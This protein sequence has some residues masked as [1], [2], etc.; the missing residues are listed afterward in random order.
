[1]YVHQNNCKNWCKINKTHHTMY[2]CTRFSAL[3]YNPSTVGNC[4]NDAF[5]LQLNDM[6]ITHIGVNL[7]YKIR[8]NYPKSPIT[9]YYCLLFYCFVRCLFAGVFLAVS[10]TAVLPLLLRELFPALPFSVQPLQQLSSA[11]L[12]LFLPL[13]QL[14]SAQLSLFLPLPLSFSTLF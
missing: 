3:P 8:I 6:K 5:C 4:R 14:S 10:F 1:M 11:R 2:V 12:S 9:A 7:L 13:R